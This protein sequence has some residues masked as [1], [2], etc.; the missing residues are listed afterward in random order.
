MPVLA[1]IDIVSVV[2][3]AIQRSGTVESRILFYKV[4]L[5]SVGVA[6]LERRVEVTSIGV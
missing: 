1:F 5:L 2:V 6:L 3:K 4:Y